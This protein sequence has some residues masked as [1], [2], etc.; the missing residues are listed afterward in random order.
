MTSV[1]AAIAIFVV[2]GRS[3]ISAASTMARSTSFINA[4]S[5]PN[6]LCA[7]GNSSIFLQTAAILSCKLICVVANSSTMSKYFSLSATGLAC[8]ATRVRSRKLI[9]S[10]RIFIT[11]RIMDGGKELLDLLPLHS[12]LQAGSTRSSA[13]RSIVSDQYSASAIA[14][15]CDSN[16]RLDK[17]R[18]PPSTSS[19]FISSSTLWNLIKGRRS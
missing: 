11:S 16:I 17:S 5:F 1:S 8:S 6:S 10:S 13:H 4:I 19:F 9:S 2:S 12:P 18:I 14:I 15:P 3:S 7:S